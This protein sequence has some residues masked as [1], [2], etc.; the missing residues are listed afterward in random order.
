[1][2]KI[3]ITGGIG[4][5]KTYITDILRR[6]NYPVY[7]SDV[8]S[9][10]YINNKWRRF[11]FGYKKEYGNITSIGISTGYL[12]SSISS[13]Q[14]HLFFMNLGA[15][16][17]LMKKRMGLGFSLENFP[18]AI[19]SYTKYDEIPPSIFRTAFYYKPLS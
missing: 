17:R 11:E 2:K 6:L 12:F 14:S 8:V 18:I 3:G 19:K 5:G 15:R 13:F 10:R 7:N 9:K 16:S 4:V 1:M